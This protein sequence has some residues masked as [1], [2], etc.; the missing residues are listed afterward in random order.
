MKRNKR[1][2][3][4]TKIKD[5]EY[6]IKVYCYD[7]NGGMKK[8]DCEIEDCPLYRYRPFGKHSKKR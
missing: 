2:L 4:H 5:M 8:I 3:L 6:A 1:T 7:H